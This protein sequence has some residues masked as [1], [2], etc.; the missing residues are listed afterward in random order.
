MHLIVNN[1]VIKLRVFTAIFPL[2][3]PRVT[4]V[5]LVHRVQ[6]GLWET[7]GGKVEGVSQDSEE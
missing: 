7:L 6:L 3:L 2:L 4:K 1:H 5:T